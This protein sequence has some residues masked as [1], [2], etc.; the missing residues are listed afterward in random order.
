MAMFFGKRLYQFSFNFRSLWKPSPQM[1]LD[2]QYLQKSNGT[3][4]LGAEVRN[5]D[6]ME[7]D[8]TSRADFIRVWYSTMNTV[9]PCKNRFRFQGQPYVRK[10]A[11][12]LR[13]DF[14][15]VES[16]TLT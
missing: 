7:A 9:L 4:A 14:I 15:S 16:A 13:T 1:T 2:R 11:Q 8:L 10:H 5:Y 6:F 3:G 12:C